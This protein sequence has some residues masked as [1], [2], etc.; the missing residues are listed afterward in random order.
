MQNFMSGISGMMPG[1]GGGAPDD[2]VPWW[3]KYAGKGAGITSGVG[4][5][6]NRLVMQKNAF[7]RVMKWG[8]SLMSY[9]R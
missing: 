3:M 5:R 8:A 6:S 2:G 7:K 9:M 4:K 1:G